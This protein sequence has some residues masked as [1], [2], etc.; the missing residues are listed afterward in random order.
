[1]FER[2]ASRLR[3][4]HQFQEKYTAYRES[5][6]RL[7]DRRHALKVVS[8]CGGGCHVEE[9]IDVLRRWLPHL[10]GCCRVWDIMSVFGKSSLR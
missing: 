9:I 1:M 8:E 2:S 5:S 6:L 10:V 7:E 3:D 4:R